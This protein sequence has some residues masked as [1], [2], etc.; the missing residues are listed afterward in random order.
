[1][2]LTN[3]QWPAK[4][5]CKLTSHE[6]HLL[7]ANRNFHG[8]ATCALPHEKQEGGLTV[9]KVPSATLEMFLWAP[10]PHA[11]TYV[12]QACTAKP[13]SYTQYG[14]TAADPSISRTHRRHGTLRAVA[15]SRTQCSKLLAHSM[16]GFNK[17]N[18]NQELLS[19][20]DSDD[21]AAY[22]GSFQRHCLTSGIKPCVYC[23]WLRHYHEH[24]DQTRN[25]L[26]GPLQI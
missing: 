12:H 8:G 20:W 22:L 14:V 17:S 7:F 1:M 18:G 13:T 2:H 25:C 24:L 11:V 21:C 19:T 26:Y 23:H 10:A 9:G 15:S 3:K 6:T 16:V 4:T 5:I